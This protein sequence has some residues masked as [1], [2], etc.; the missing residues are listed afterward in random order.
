MTEKL[1]KGTFYAKET[2]YQHLKERLKKW[3]DEEGENLSISKFV[4]KQ[5]DRMKSELAQLKKNHELHVAIVDLYKTMLEFKQ[6]VVVAG[7]T[8]AP[9]KKAQKTEKRIQE[10][11]GDTSRE[12]SKNWEERQA[13]GK[14]KY[15]SEGNEL[16]LN[17]KGEWVI[18]L[19]HEENPHTSLLAEIKQF[20]KNKN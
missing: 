10:M 14:R 16:F 1:I 4:V 15:D 6:S 11:V 9:S 7:A 18:S 13:L 2:A 3:N 12:S 5:P 8:I 20:F 19:K 17:E